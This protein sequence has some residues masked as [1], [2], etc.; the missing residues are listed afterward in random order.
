MNNLFVVALFFISFLVSLQQANAD[1]CDDFAKALEYASQ[2]RGLKIL[3]PVDCI[4]VDKTAYDSLQ[5]KDIKVNSNDEYLKYDEIF[6]KLLGFIPSDYQY[7]NCFVDESMQNTAAYYDP[8]SKRAIIPNWQELSFDVLV[9]EAVHALQDQHFSLEKL[10]KN[11]LASTDRAISFS[12]LIE[13][14]AVRIQN[15]FLTDNPQYK[16]AEGLSSQQIQENSDCTFPKTLDDLS[17]FP[18]GFGPIFVERLAKKGEL[19]NAFENPPFSSSSVIHSARYPD[20]VT[21]PVKPALNK[22]AKLLAVRPESEITRD[23]L[24]Q[25]V[26]RL[27]VGTVHRMREAV[28]AS[29]GWVGDSAVLFNSNAGHALIWSVRMQDEKDSKELY[30]ALVDVI[31]SWG[32]SDLNSNSSRIIAS[33]PGLGRVTLV[34]DTNTIHFGRVK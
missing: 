32:F 1:A 11:S 33:K 27:L 2:Y 8:K 9:H 10:S 19:N 34:M 15:L 23:T 25:Y 21:M 12:A 3:N 4:S 16:K 22:I 29:K 24:G 26:I 14:D 20:S 17:L 30:V 13:G 31:K 7:A 6:F 18:Y 5:E 28:L